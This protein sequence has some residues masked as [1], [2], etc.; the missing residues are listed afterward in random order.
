MDDGW[1][2]VDD[3]DQKMGARVRASAN[4]EGIAW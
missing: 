3:A 2:M 4:G 1:W